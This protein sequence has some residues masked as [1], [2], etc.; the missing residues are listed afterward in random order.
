MNFSGERYRF[1]KISAGDL[2]EREAPEELRRLVKGKI[3]LV[4][5][6]FEEGRDSYETPIGRLSGLEINAFAIQTNLGDGGIGE[7]ARPLAVAFDLLCGYLVVFLFN[8]RAVHAWR[9][10]PAGLIN[11][12]EKMLQ[13]EARWKT[14]W[15]LAISLV[16]AFAFSWM[17]FRALDVW[18]SY[19]GV[20]AGTIFHQI[21]EVI[22]ENPGAESESHPA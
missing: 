3:L 5:G 10:L 21:I 7:I 6:T 11:G 2:L 15:S 16:G 22:V 4:G 18:A 13:D 9:P 17:M 8:Y 12:L 1:P 20:F 14:V 19:I